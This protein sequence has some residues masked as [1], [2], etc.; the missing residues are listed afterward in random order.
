[1]KRLFV[2]AALVSLTWM[3]RA[4]TAA[5][6]LALVNADWKVTELQQGLVAKKAVFAS[7]Y[8]VPQEVSLLEV[9]PKKFKFNVQEHN[10]MERTG[11]VSRREGAVAALNGTFYNMKVG[12]SV[13]Y[14]QK[15]GIVIDT[16]STGSYQ[17]NGAL[18]IKKGKIAIM[19]WDKQAEKA[20]QAKPGKASVMAAGPL[21][22]LDGKDCSTEG[23]NRSFCDN[24]HP[25]SAVVLT[26][27]KK[28]L[29][30]V[31]DG[32]RKGKCEG[33][34]IAEFTHLVRVLGGVDALNMD[35]GGSS[36]LWSAAMP[37][38]GVINT[39]SDK[40]GERKVANSIGVYAK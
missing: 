39:P 13:S 7:L 40:S 1:M 28:V 29:L 23:L 31:V 35:G 17:S 16:T 14:L 22:R 8:G 3:G 36:T 25:R 5:D 12:Y 2:M 21:M 37:D 9:S 15:D 4:Q 26:K 6:S 30:V 32:R 20:M 38:D 33:V 19:A 24:K 11:E 18:Y 27:D 34:S 10:A